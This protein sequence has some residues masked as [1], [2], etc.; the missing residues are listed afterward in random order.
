M[1][2]LYIGIK[3][4]VLIFISAQAYSFSSSSYLVA[5]F[6]ISFFDYEEAHAH[7]DQSSAQNL[8]IIDLEKKLLTYVNTNSLNKASV[9]AEEIL[10]IDKKNQEA[11]LAYLINAKLNNLEMPFNEFKKERREEDLKI[12]KKQLKLLKILGFQAAI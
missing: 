7:Y 11:W 8:N 12:V 6:A 2:K 5:N 1:H 9:V 10:R 4:L 3:C